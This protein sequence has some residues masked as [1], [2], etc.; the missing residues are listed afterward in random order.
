MSLQIVV[1]SAPMP[2]ETLNGDAVVVRES[3]ELTLLA[4]VDA[5]G[6][7]EKA[8]EVAALAVKA[9]QQAP[10]HEGIER[11]M[12]GLDAALRGTRGAAATVCLLQGGELSGC[13]VGNVEMRVRGA[14]VPFTLSPGVLGRQVRNYRFFRGTFSGNARLVMFSDGLAGR[15]ALTDFDRFS[16]RAAC[17]ALIEKF[18][19]GSDDVTVLVADAGGTGESR[20]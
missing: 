1:S 5:L 10:L 16:A 4:V 14:H 15:F 6:H 8:H 7:G 20:R 2:G 3:D 17:D 12:H 19:R 9:L 11:I 18:S 13:G